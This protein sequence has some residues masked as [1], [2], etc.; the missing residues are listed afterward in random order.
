MVGGARGRG[1]GMLV[2]IL[3]GTTGMPSMDMITL[4]LC[5]I[6]TTIGKEKDTIG[7]NQP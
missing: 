7:P 5:I 3:L 1:M 6:D 4:I 2:G